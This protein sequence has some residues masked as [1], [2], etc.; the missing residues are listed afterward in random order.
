MG[1]KLLPM[2]TVFNSYTALLN[3]TG[4]LV[5]A[6]Y[7]LLFSLHPDITKM[8]VIINQV[9]LFIKKKFI[10]QRRFIQQQN[11]LNTNNGMQ[12]I[13]WEAG[14]PGEGELN[15]MKWSVVKSN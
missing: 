3:C 6:L 13:L 14:I 12:Y 9:N 10:Q 8:P 2:T 5:I 11:E 7:S 4:S 15:I 1:L